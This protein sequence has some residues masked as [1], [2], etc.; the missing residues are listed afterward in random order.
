MRIEDILSSEK[1]I[2]ILD[3]ELLIAF[4]LMKPREWVIAR[5]DHKLN[6]KDLKKY[7][8]YSKRRRMG[9]PIAYITGKKE[10]YGFSFDVN[11]NV[12]T[13]RPSTETVIN[14][15]SDYI[16]NPHDEVR[17]ADSG[18]V[19]AVK[20]LREF[21]RLNAAADIGTGSGC[22]AVTLA[23]LHPN[24]RFIAADICAE[25]I[26]TAKINAKKHGVSERISFRRGS[27]LEP[28]MGLNEPFIVV[29]NPPY[30]P[31]GANIGKEVKDCEPGKA[32]FAGEEG[33]DVLFEIARQ[34]K[35]HPFCAGF[36]VECAES[37]AK[38]LLKNINLM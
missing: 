17:E 30:V 33:T 11:K 12:L 22:I 1:D 21:G 27:C 13:P 25:A 15:F 36:I 18:V 14:L 26:I 23:L 20:K 32:L 9:E 19:C 3:C 28:V 6:A 31:I 4:A 7:S 38:E 24:F 2:P 16:A 29:S 35:K 10:F 37:Q 5:K 8:S 34:C